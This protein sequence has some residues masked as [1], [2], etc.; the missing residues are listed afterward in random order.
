MNEKIFEQTKPDTRNAYLKIFAYFMDIRLMKEEQ[1]RRHF[2]LMELWSYF[3]FYFLFLFF[4]EHPPTG[5]VEVGHI[6]F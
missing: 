3:I 1:P 4:M 2:Q 5:F 6:W